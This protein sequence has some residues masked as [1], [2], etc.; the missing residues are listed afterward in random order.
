[1]V[2]NCWQKIIISKW[3]QNYAGKSEYLLTTTISDILI[4]ISQ[5]DIETKTCLDTL[6][7]TGRS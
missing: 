1:M 5:S 3:R 2:V 6:I 4:T 7:C